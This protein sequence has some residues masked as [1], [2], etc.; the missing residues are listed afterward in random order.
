MKIIKMQSQ[1][2]LRKLYAAA[3]CCTCTSTC[4]CCNSN[5]CEAEE[6]ADDPVVA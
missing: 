6:P 1:R 2:L 5:T 3:G 4:T